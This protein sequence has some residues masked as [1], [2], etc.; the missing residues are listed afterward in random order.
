[1]NPAREY[2]MTVSD[3]SFNLNTHTHR[4][5]QNEPFFAALSRR[6][7]KVAT[8]SVPTAGVRVTEDGRYEMV[9]NPDFMERIIEECGETKE[10]REN[11]YRWVRGILMHEFYHL[12]Y[13]HVT[14]RM[15]EGGVSKLWNVAT[16]LAINTHIADDIPPSGCVPGR[17]P[18]AELETGLSADAYYKI[19]QDDEQPDDADSEGSNDSSGDGEDGEGQ[20]QGEGGEDEEQD[21][22]GGTGNGSGGGMGDYDSLDD[23][24][25]WGESEGTTGNIAQE[26][27]KDMVKKAAEEAGKKGWGSVSSRMRTRIMDSIT[28]KVDWRNVL[29]N[30]VKASQKSSRRS[31]VKRIN[32]RFPYIHAGKRSERVARVAISIDQ[33]GSVSDSMLQAFFSE[34]EQLAKYAEFVVVPFDTVVNDDLVYTWKKGEKKQWERVMC[35]GT[36]FNAPSQYV[37]DNKFDGHIVLTDMCAPKPI[38]SKCRRMWMTD[39][40]GATQPYFK[41]H[42]KVLEITT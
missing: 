15:P 25:G 36:C 40:Y 23:H 6:I 20:G 17:G 10:N 2:A 33:S 27:L 22:S 38:P 19:L 3:S 31:T 21:D 37:N 24:S 11:P 9:Y 13:G 39:S 32:R 1:M 30:F 28:T 35:G 29:R 26:R 8:T 12:I 14:T 5:L 42:E 41:T 18:F 4:L 7:D 34:L 16:D